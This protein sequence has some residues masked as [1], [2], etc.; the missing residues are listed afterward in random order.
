[1]MKKADDHE[2]DIDTD[3]VTDRGEKRKPSPHRRRRL[4]KVQKNPSAPKRFKSAFIFFTMERHPQ[5]RKQLKESGVKDC[6]TPDVA[7][8]VSEQWRNLTPAERA[9]WDEKAR[10]DKERFMVEKKLYRGPWKV[11]SPDECKKDPSAPKRPMS[12]F[13]SYSNGKRAAV[14][15]QNPHYSNADIS[16]ALSK[17][18]KEAPQEEKDF[19]INKEA[20]LR[21][22]YKED[23]VTWREKCDKDYTTQTQTV[24]DINASLRTMLQP[25]DY[26]PSQ[27][28]ESVLDGSLLNHELLGFDMRRPASSQR[29]DNDYPNAN[30]HLQDY[31]IPHQHLGEPSQFPFD[32]PSTTTSLHPTSQMFGQHL[33][34]ATQQAT[35]RV[36]SD[37]ANNYLNSLRP[38]QITSNPLFQSS[39]NNIYGADFPATSN[40]NQD[41]SYNP[42][43]MGSGQPMPLSNLAD[44]ALT[45][46]QMMQSRVRQRAILNSN[47]GELFA[48]MHTSPAS[49]FTL[50]SVNQEED[51][52]RREECETP[53]SKGE[54]KK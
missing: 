48:S 16:K 17:M 45:A 5:V 3:T 4:S 7:K 15:A 9:V 8:I 46:D 22:K 38:R 18:W 34:N 49:N 11:A 19:H 36:I 30:Q 13:L 39:Q 41:E 53:L 23:I 37:E 32:L 35:P 26:F 14:K 40:R 33:L 28:N 12:S 47:Q 27:N 20:A 29:Y 50:T 43:I 42:Y 31:N 21:K 6:K 2:E 44:Y 25:Q 24:P 10:V 1:M 52:Q 51:R 54:D